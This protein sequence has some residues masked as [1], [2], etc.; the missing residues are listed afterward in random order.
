MPVPLPALELE[1]MGLPPGTTTDDT[2]MARNL[3]RSLVERDGLDTDDVLARHIALAP[4]WVP[5]RQEP[6]P[7][8]AVPRRRRG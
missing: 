6:H 5:G 8:R 4:D 1:W 2:A 3:M 7:D